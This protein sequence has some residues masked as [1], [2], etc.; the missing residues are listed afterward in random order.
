MHDKVEV[1]VI[2]NVIEVKPISGTKGDVGAIDIGLPF[3]SLTQAEFDLLSP[4]DPDTLYD[5]TDA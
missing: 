2:Q 3:I 4:P 1:T 5:I